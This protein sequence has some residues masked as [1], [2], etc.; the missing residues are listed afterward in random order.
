MAA[1]ESHWDHMVKAGAGWIGVCKIPV[2]PL[3]AYSA[4]P[5]VPLEYSVRI[6][7]LVVDA[8]FPRAVSVV[9]AAAMTLA[10]R[11]NWAEL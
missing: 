1:A 11:S 3:A 2:Y 6:Y 7:R 4:C 9:P 10:K 5:S 8:E